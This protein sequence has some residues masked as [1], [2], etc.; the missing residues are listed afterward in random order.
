[1]RRNMEHIEWKEITNLADFGISK[2]KEK[3]IKEFLAKE[4]ANAKTHYVLAG[5][6]FKNFEDEGDETHPI[7]LWAI[8][9]WDYFNPF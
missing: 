8:N 3:N 9:A 4:G 7:Y 6:A 5:S 1:M 2:T